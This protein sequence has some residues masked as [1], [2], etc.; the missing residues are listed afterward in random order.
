MTSTFECAA[1]ASNGL[2]T[3]TGRSI[4]DGHVLVTRSIQGRAPELL[5]G[6][7]FDLDQGGFRLTDSEAPFGIDLTY[8]LNLNPDD[9]IVQQ[10]LMLTPTFLHGVQ[11]WGTGTGRTVAIEADSTANSAQ[12]GH[13]S[14]NSGGIAGAAPPSVVGHTES[15]GYVNGP[16][17]LTP[18]TS[19]GG[20]IAIG[21]WMYLFH[22]QLS[23]VAGPATPA[24]WTVVSTA[25]LGDISYV[26]FRRKR[27]SGDAG[28]TVSGLTGS[29][30]FGTLLWV[31]GA[32]DTTPVI[33]TAAVSNAPVIV[34]DGMTA[35]NPVLGLTFAYGQG[36]AN[37]N[38]PTAANVQ[39][40]TWLYN[41]G[42]GTNP[43]QITVAAVGKS[44]AGS[45]IPVSVSYSAVIQ[46]SL[47]GLSL[48]I[49]SPEVDV[50]QRIIAKG[51]AAQLGADT[52]YL[53]TGRFKFAATSLNPWSTI[54]GVGS[55]QQ[56][57]DTKITWAATRGSSTTSGS[58]DFL[59]FFVGIRNPATGDWYVSPRQVISTTNPKL[60]TWY[61]FS[62]FFDVNSTIPTTAEVVFMHGTS[63]QEY[64]I[65][66]WFD[67]I[68]ITPPDQVGRLYWFSGDSP[69][70]PNTPELAL[71]PG[72]YG[73][74]SGASVSWTGTVGNSVSQILMP[75]L[76]AI[77]SS[78]RFDG[79]PTDD[80]CSTPVF[81]NDPITPA[82]GQWYTLIGISELTYAARQSLY[83]VIGRAPVTAVNDVRGWASGQFTLLTR[84]LND[85]AKA[86]DTFSPGR[87][88][89][90]R[91]P[92]PQ[93]PETEWYL[94]I[95]HVAEARIGKD[96]RRPERLWTVPFFRVERPSGMI[97]FASGD[98]WAT[99][100]DK[101]SWATIRNTGD[102]MTVLTGETMSTV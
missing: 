68:G 22:G 42:V 25:T 26:L 20:S 43:R 40:S 35:E 51:K 15:A 94:A 74:V 58:T 17:T 101:G 70:P 97:D 41:H 56:V 95:G 87:I 21:D 44:N 30:G 24:G 7:E 46:N 53:L 86:I 33:K 9:R 47:L 4:P 63:A 65:D 27:Q 57:R 90:L 49:P 2:I 91:N 16:Y 39:G 80:Y 66:W 62:F 78:C 19:G 81:L 52:G 71:G 23:A 92:D 76:V 64:G 96:L 67:Q 73:V 38:P 89:F 11:G 29:F 102:W 84:T 36:Q 82:R 98:T 85:R 50:N 75:M 100:R 88:L 3:V 79:P 48:L 31:R 55:W 37:A 61:D 28:V 1:D 93:F 77:D 13:F 34:F 60:N 32:S 12:V 72:W 14:L 18:P 5:R 83:D 8:N 45:V 10:N 59:R 54:R 69:V 99:V 6:G